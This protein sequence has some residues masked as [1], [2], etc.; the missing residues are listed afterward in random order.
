M[1]EKLIRLLRILQAIQ[2]YPES[3]PRSWLRNVIQLY[4]RSIAISGFW[5][6]LPL[7]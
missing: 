1:T 6:G 5:T 2:A 7:S 3:Q 4:A